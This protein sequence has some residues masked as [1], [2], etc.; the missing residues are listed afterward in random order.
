MFLIIFLLMLLTA[1]VNVAKIS[2]HSKTMYYVTLSIVIL[3]YV[4]TKLAG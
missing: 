4:L 1:Y 2:G 3:L